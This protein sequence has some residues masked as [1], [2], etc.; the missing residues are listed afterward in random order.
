MGR[1]NTEVSLLQRDEIIAYQSHCVGLVLGVPATPVQ[2]SDI[3]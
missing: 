3:I 1:V 2:V